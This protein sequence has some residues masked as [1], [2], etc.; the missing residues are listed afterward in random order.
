[1][2][3]N[4]EDFARDVL[5]FTVISWRYTFNLY[6]VIIINSL[7]EPSLEVLGDRSLGVTSC[8]CSKSQN[9]EESNLIHLDMIPYYNW[10]F[11]ELAQ[12]F[13]RL[14]KSWIEHTLVIIFIEK[15]DKVIFAE[16]SM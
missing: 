3:F 11:L 13:Y 2:M 14:G 9:E 5:L 10:C 4:Y 8:K 15:L 7:F 12:L 16:N 6:N 1:M